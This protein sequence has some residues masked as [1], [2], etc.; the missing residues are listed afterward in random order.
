MSK[1]KLNLY[2]VINALIAGVLIVVLSNVLSFLDFFITCSVVI[3]IIVVYISI[4]VFLLV[5]FVKR[6]GKDGKSVRSKHK[7]K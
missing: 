4:N 2:L 3:G 1:K 7:S 5:R 6:G